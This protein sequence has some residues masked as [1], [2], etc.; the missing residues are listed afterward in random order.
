MCRRL[1][2]GDTVLLVRSYRYR[3]YVTDI[4]LASLDEARSGIRP[5]LADE[6]ARVAERNA[7]VSWGAALLACG[8][9]EPAE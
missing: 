1:F 7:K 5:T 6:R 3:I 9:R 2:Y 4:A 8:E